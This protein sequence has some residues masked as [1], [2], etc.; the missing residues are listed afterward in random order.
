MQKTELPEGRAAFPV[1]IPNKLTR[2]TLEDSAAGKGI[3]SFDSVDDLLAS[4]EE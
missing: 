2:K 1:R 3:Q 4:W